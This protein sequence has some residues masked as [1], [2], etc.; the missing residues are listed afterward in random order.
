MRSR[1]TCRGLAWLRK[2]APPTTGHSVD[3][4]QF[5][6]EHKDQLV[7]KP[8]DEYGGKGIVLG[9]EVD[10]AAWA[11]ALRTALREPYIVQERVSLPSEPYP[12]VVDGTSGR[13]GPHARHRPVR[14]LRPVRRWLPYTPLHG[15][16]AQ[17]DGRGRIVGADHAGGE[18][19][20]RG[21]SMQPPSLTLGIEE[22]Y[23]IIDPQTRELQLVHHRDP[24]GRPSRPRGGEA[25]AAPVDGRDRHQGLSHARRGARRARSPAPHRDGARGTKGPA[26][27]PPPGRTRSRPGSRRRSRRSSAT[28]ASSR[29]SPTSR[30]S[31]SSSA[32]TSTSASRIAIS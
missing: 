13:G 21:E 16:A 17:C 12:S 5:I 11:E 32:R 25:G 20:A 18:A 4:V 2:D 27:S 28:S 15:G 30:S 26:R 7:L 6:V 1:R 3:L 29:I 24:R 23:Q 9:W 14:R 22:E 8:N 10:D 31:C 19:L